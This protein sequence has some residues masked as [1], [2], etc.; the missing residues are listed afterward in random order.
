MRL[1]NNQSAESTAGCVISYVHKVTRFL[2]AVQE[3]VPLQVEQANRELQ[4]IQESPT[5]KHFC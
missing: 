4:A 2:N 1:N 3:H 5:G